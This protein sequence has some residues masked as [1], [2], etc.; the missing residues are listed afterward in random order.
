MSYPACT[1]I[2][3]RSTQAILLA[4]ISES[5]NDSMQMSECAATGDAYANTSWIRKIYS[6]VIL[7]GRKT[8]FDSFPI[9]Y[10]RLHKSL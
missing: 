1:R 7:A 6:S 5:S 4:H 9:S 8:V 3:W 2:S 10:Q